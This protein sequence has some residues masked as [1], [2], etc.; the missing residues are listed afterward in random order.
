M[1][2]AEALACCAC[3]PL[4]CV[5][6]DMPTVCG[7]GACLIKISDAPEHDAGR[8]SPGL[9][10]LLGSSQGQGHLWVREPELQQ[11]AQQDCAWAL[12]C[13]RPSP[14]PHALGGGCHCSQAVG[15]LG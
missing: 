13:G 2:T 4:L 9:L 8:C 7:V 6:P 5:Y 10:R 3:C 15:Q 1:T 14:C 12:F 11:H